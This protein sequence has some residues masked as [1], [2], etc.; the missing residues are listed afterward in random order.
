MA[1]RVS[2]TADALSRRVHSNPFTLRTLTLERPARACALPKRPARDKETTMFACTGYA[3]KDAASPLAPFTFDRRDP[4]PD[5]VVIEIVYCGVCHSD[6][7]TVRNEWGG[8]MYPSR[9]R[10]RD[11][12]PGDGGRQRTSASSRSATCAGVGCMVDSLPDLPILQ[13]GARA[14]LRGRP[15][16]A[17]TTAEDKAL[18]GHTYRRLFEPYRR[19]RA[20]RA[21][22]CRTNLDSAAAAPLLCAGITTYSPLRHWNAGPGRRSA[23]SVSAA[24]ATWA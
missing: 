13:G 22:R 8:T 4:G 10:P 2:L 18:G 12:R 9:A 3:A 5:D 6:L 19:D 7:H 15:S 23:S 14:I 17:P 20:L 21:R 24:S 16:S 11:R 1:E